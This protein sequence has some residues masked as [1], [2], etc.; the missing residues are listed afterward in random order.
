MAV[1][2]AANER[3]ERRKKFREENVSK[4]YEALIKA[5]NE[6]GA[7]PS[8]FKP[9]TI[10][11]LKDKRRP[12]KIDF[13]LAPYVEEQYQKLR[14]NILPGPK[15]S[16]VKVVMVAATDHNEGGTTT[17]S[18]LASTL[19][20]SKDCKILLIDANCR[21]PALDGVF[22]GQKEVEGLSDLVLSDVSSPDQCIYQT[23]LA[24]LFVLPGGRP[25]SSPSYIFD[26]E[27]MDK[28]LTTLRERFDFVIFDAS[29]LDAY[30]E[31]FFLASKVDGVVLVVEVERTKKEMV[32]RIKKEL[33]W[34]GVNI[35]GVVLNKKKKY[36][37]AFIE[38]F[39]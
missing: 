6:L 36:I 14:R 18:I 25:V 15:H 19:A 22:D 29:P 17:A 38:R 9:V 37:P 33:E 35:L 3:A 32:R 5:E 26:G 11:L 8:K 7:E 34:A 39:L 31:S 24:N 27:S 30:S 10:K 28:L 12:P 2:S 13:D 1:G 4:I 20:K 23:N 21:T 16:P